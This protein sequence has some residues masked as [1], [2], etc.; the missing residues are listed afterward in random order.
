MG[1]LLKQ[2]VG[3]ITFTF[4]LAGFYQKY[5][6]GKTAPFTITQLKVL[7]HF[8]WLFYPN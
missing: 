4:L 6:F 5:V 7:T 8:T 1:T 3:T 2:S